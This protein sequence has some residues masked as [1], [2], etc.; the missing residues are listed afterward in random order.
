MRLLA[1]H[2]LLRAVVLPRFGDGFSAHDLASRR[3]GMISY[4][5]PPAAAGTSCCRRRRRWWRTDEEKDAPAEP[6]SVRWITGGAAKI[7]P[8]IRPSSSSC[9]IAA[10]HAA[11]SRTMRPSLRTAQARGFSS[12][13]P[14]GKK[15][16]GP[17]SSRK[18]FRSLQSPMRVTMRPRRSSG[19]ARSRSLGGSITFPGC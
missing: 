6:P 4:P 19:S 7:P 1:H 8:R 12:S 16:G 18:L 2:H 5:P 17:R 11:A 9:I 13:E 15:D 10:Y 14:P 3:C